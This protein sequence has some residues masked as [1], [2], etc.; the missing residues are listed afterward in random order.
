LGSDGYF[1][2]NGA[3]V[4]VPMWNPEKML[5]KGSSWKDVIGAAPVGRLSIGGSSKSQTYLATYM[6]LKQVLGI[7]YFKR[8]LGLVTPA[9]GEGDGNR[10]SGPH[11]LLLRAQA[12]AQRTHSGAHAL[13]GIVGGDA[14]R[15]YC[16]GSLWR[17]CRADQGSSNHCAHSRL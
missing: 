6:G 1:A 7:D 17:R 16:R 2:F 5:F 12:H 14:H 4:F 8:L 10:G 3:Y 11:C 9:S 15:R 13:A